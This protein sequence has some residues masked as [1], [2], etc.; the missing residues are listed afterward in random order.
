MLMSPS[1]AA[2]MSAAVNLRNSESISGCS[3][4]SYSGIAPSR[5][6][7]WI[8]SRE[9]LSSISISS[10][11]CWNSKTVS[12]SGT[13]FNQLGEP[14]GHLKVCC[15]RSAFAQLHS[16][17]AFDISPRSARS[18][19]FCILWRRHRRQGQHVGSDWR[20]RLLGSRHL[21]PL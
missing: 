16:A 19:A 18:L 3:N 13:C 11:H 10:S 4:P 12:G 1:G 15:F 17:W 6:D 9:A 20:L 7:L 5:I 8:A 21:L 2:I 14:G